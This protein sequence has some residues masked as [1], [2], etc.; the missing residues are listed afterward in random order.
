MNE[1]L[2]SSASVE[3]ATP[4][5]LFRQLDAEFHFNLDPCSTHENAKCADHFTKTE[6]GLSQNWGV[7]GCFAIRH[8]GESCRSGSRK[9]TTRPRKA[10]LW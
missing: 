3:W 2:F 7:K 10:R 4:W 5:E 8:T 9:R 1:S 6:D